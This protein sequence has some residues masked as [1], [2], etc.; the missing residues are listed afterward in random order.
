MRYLIDAIWLVTILHNVLL[1]GTGNRTLGAALAAVIIGFSILLGQRMWNISRG[2][3]LT[4][5][6][7]S[8]LL[9]YEAA[10]AL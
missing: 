8:L 10:V 9:A 6:P 7:L 3:S 2:A 5:I 1:V 4:L